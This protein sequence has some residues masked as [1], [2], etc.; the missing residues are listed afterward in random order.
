MG[1]DLDGRKTGPVNEL[2]HG[3]QADAEPRWAVWGT[4]SSAIDFFILSMVWIVAVPSL[5]QQ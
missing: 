2:I 1:V 4:V 3:G 5:R